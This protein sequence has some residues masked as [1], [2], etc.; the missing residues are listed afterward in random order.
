MTV[1]LNLSFFVKAVEDLWHF[2]LPSPSIP[3]LLLLEVLTGSFVVSGHL[4]LSSYVF[5]IS[6]ICTLYTL[7][8]YGLYSLMLSKSYSFLLYSGKVLHSDVPTVWLFAHL[9]FIHSNISSIVFYLIYYPLYQIFLPV[10]FWWYLFQLACLMISSHT[11]S[12]LFL[13]PWK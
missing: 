12:F 2:F 11:F 1:F 7:L 3:F 5:L 8:F 10:S 13:I 9:L 4:E 6:Q